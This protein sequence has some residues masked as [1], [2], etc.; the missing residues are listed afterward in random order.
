MTSLICPDGIQ[1]DESV[2]VPVQMEVI[3]LQS[4]IRI[5]GILVWKNFLKILSFSC[6]WKSRLIRPS[7][8]HLESTSSN[9]KLAGVNN[10][11]VTSAV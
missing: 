2:G 11:T 5:S 9:H 10:L 7:E 8:G 3:L 4:L 6:E 1:M